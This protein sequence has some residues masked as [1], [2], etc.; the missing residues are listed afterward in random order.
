MPRS[1]RV[2]VRAA[3]LL[4]SPAR[5]DGLRAAIQA[6]SVLLRRHVDALHADASIACWPRLDRLPHGEI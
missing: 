1:A 5:A 6:D 2:L 3:L 4:A